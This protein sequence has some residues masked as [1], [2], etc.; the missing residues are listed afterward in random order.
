MADWNNVIFW[1]VIV[2]IGVFF[3]A[4]IVPASSG[5]SWSLQDLGKKAYPGNNA[6]GWLIILVGGY[7]VFAFYDSF[8][9]NKIS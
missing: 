3:V 1:G 4:Q 9:R 7:I 8:L 6:V 2:V 5:S